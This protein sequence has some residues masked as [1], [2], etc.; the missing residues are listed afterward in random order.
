MPANTHTDE[1]P[2]ASRSAA[3]YVLPVLFPA[4][5]AIC[6][7]ATATA[8][9]TAQLLWGV[10]AIAATTATAGF[11]VWRDR[12]S[13]T[14]ALTTAESRTRLTAI[15]SRA[16]EPM[17]NALNAVT[18]AP[19]AAERLTALEVLISL[20]TDHAHTQC[21]LPQPPTADVRS[22]FYELVG[23]HLERRRFAGRAD[24]PRPDFRPER[25][26][27]EHEAVR[28]ARGEHPLMIHDLH[29]SPPAHFQDSR[30]RT[31]RSFI[32]APVRGGTTSYGLLVIDADQPSAFTAIDRN[33]ILLMSAIL[34]AGFAHVSATSQSPIPACPLHFTATCEQSRHAHQHQFAPTHQRVLA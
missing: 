6:S 26:L 11:T 13:V 3:R 12:Q 8:H 24:T 31:Y 15:L 21:W 17:I 9:G 14:A 27:H 10:G 7:A 2:T 34:G 4:T 19:T 1:S 22:I 5:A 16:A 29:T 18:A 25:S 20:V 33:H 32:A 30:G 23:D 28:L